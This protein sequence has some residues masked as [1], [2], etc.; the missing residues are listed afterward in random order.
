MHDCD[1]VKKAINEYVRRKC[2]MINYSVV[3][4]RLQNDLQWTTTRCKLR[5]LTS[6]MSIFIIWRYSDS[7]LYGRHA[8]WW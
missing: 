1:A 3:A 8:W 4:V 2:L 6:A 7:K 5:E